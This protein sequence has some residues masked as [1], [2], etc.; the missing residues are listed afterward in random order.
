MKSYLFK[1][2]LS[3]LLILV[4]SFS[5]AQ[6]SSDI[7]FDK[8]VRKFKKVDEGHILTFTY[9]FTYSGEFKLNI[10]PPKVDCSCTIVKLPEGDIQPN[11]TNTITIKFDTKDKIGY[12]LREVE[13]HFV[14]DMMDSRA[15]EKK[16]YFKGVVKASQATKK[17]FKEKKK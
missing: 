7:K 4:A 3:L 13:L 5:F 2:N 14:S 6:I 1:I 10:I 16:L 11:S 17:A 9:T 12:Q 8:T 15:I